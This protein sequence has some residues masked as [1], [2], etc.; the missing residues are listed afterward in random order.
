MMCIIEIDN[1]FAQRSGF[2]SR[3]PWYIHA[4]ICQTSNSQMNWKNHNKTLQWSLII[5]T[6]SRK[7]E[8][9]FVFNAESN[10][11]GS[12]WRGLLSNCPGVRLIIT[13]LSLKMLHVLEKNVGNF[14]PFLPENL[15]LDQIPVAYVHGNIYNLYR[16]KYFLFTFHLYLELSR[17]NTWAICYFIK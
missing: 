17:I 3:C 13:S 12:R 4:Y 2:Y 6:V 16:H 15:V 9:I 7:A 5:K 14:I 8:F 1:V 11:Q 10:I